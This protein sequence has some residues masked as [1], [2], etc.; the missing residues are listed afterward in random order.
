[1]TNKGCEICR[2]TVHNTIRMQNKSAYVVHKQYVKESWHQRYEHV[3]KM[4]L[5]LPTFKKLSDQ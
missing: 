1:M 2:K 5:T 4:K 3:G